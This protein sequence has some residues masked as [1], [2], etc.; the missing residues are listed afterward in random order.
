MANEAWT[1]ENSNKSRL[2][3]EEYQRHHD[4]ID[5]R[6]QVVAID[7]QTERIWIDDSALEIAEQMRA[8]GVN[9]R[10]YLVRIGSECFVRKGRK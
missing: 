7:P 3:W 1:S 8:E 6:G 4:L 10:V 2:L 9:S 5:F